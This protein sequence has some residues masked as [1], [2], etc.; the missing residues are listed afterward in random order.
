M[1]GSGD[2]RL[3]VARIA[4][5]VR[6]RDLEDV[7]GRFGRLRDVVVKNGYAFVV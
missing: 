7:F 5:D 6:A 1:S 4:R 3:F 2:A